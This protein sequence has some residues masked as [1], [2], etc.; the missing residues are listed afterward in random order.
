MRLVYARSY[1]LRKHLTYEREGG[2][3]T[4]LFHSMYVLE[5]FTQ[6]SARILNISQCYS[7]IIIIEVLTILN[8]FFNEYYVRK[9]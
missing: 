4:C 2:F 5:A 9:S 1:S 6:V 8:N 3:K 7:L